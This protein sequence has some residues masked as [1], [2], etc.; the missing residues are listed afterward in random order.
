MTERE[1]LSLKCL[2][3][4]VS[5]WLCC[6][7]SAAE[8]T[9]RQVSVERGLR[10]LAVRHHLSGEEVYLCDLRGSQTLHPAATK[11]E[12]CT[13]FFFYLLCTIYFF[14]FSIH[15]FLNF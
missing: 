10:L 9:F 11:A 14:N 8:L 7:T 13:L 12:K 3:M 15:P 5:W 6:E 1:D 2:K 4:C